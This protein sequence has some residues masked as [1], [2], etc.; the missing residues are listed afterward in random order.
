M[1]RQ[2]A[3]LSWLRFTVL[4]RFRRFSA[5]KPAVQC[6]DGLWVK[7]QNTAHFQHAIKPTRSNKSVKPQDARTRFVIDTMALYVLRDG[8]EFEQAR[9]RALALGGLTAV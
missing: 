6:A 1:S 7:T 9:A 4:A 5:A 8:C 3:C 2:S